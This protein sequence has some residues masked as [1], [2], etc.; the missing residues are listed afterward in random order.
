[1]ETPATRATSL[2]VAVTTNVSVAARA[3]V[4]ARN[5]N[6][7]VNVYIVRFLLPVVMLRYS[8]TERVNL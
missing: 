1:T 2:I 3:R 7:Y 5:V 6:V 8:R 4:P